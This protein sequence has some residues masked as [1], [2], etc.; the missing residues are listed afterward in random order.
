MTYM[1]IN[2]SLLIININHYEN[3]LIFNFLAKK[4]LANRNRFAELLFANVI[5]FPLNCKKNIGPIK[6]YLE[7]SVL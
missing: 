4:I 6:S 3:Y 7:Q 2:I 1:Y 5:L